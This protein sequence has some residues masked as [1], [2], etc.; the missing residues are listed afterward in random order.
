[1]TSGAYQPTE[2]VDDP[3]FH[4]LQGLIDELM[5]SLGIRARS[6]LCQLWSCDS[7][8]IAT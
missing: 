5:R 8:E 7:H 2:L 1:M 3:K 6:R 4:Q